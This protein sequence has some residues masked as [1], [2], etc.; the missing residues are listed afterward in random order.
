VRRARRSPERVPGPLRGRLPGFGWDW[1]GHAVVPPLPSG[2]EPIRPGAIAG[3]QRGTRRWSRHRRRWPIG[4]WKP[5]S[6]Y[7]PPPEWWV[8]HNC[9]PS[10]YGM[11]PPA[12]GCGW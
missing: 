4:S 5:R 7:P 3:S 9:G 2:C 6:V 10:N 11:Q 8:S 12:F 1:L